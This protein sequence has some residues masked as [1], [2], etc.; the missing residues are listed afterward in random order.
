MLSSSHL[1]GQIG[2]SGVEEQGISADLC[3][4]EMYSKGQDPNICSFHNVSHT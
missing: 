3:G 1:G 4:T 2:I